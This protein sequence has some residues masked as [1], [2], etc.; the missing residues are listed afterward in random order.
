MKFFSKLHNTGNGIQYYKIHNEVNFKKGEKVR[1][2]TSDYLANGGDKMYFF[3]GKTKNNIGVKLRDAIINYCT[4][5]D[6]IFSELDNRIT[7]IE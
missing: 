5:K 1:V 4:S 6:T 2:L 3:K 7:I